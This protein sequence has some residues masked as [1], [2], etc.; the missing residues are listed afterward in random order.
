MVNPLWQGLIIKAGASVVCQSASAAFHLP[1][2]TPTVGGGW[3][4]ASVSYFK[5]GPLC[6]NV[7]SKVAGYVF[8]DKEII[9]IPS[10]VV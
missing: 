8:T 4:N 5:L 3:G 10:F 7:G 1:P 9:S 6:K 2:C